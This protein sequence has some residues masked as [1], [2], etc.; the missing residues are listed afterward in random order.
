MK[1]QL[2]ISTL[3]A[4]SLISQSLAAEPVPVWQK[5][6]VYTL[7]TVAGVA[8][9]GPV[10]GI[11]GLAVG[12]FVNEKMDG[13]AQ[14]KTLAP[15]LAKSQQQVDTLQDSLLA[16]DEQLAMMQDLALQRLQ[17]EVF[18]R[19]GDAQLSEQAKQQLTWL[20]DYVSQQEQV[21]IA[22][23]GFAD[24]RGD[25]QFNLDLS[26]QRLA[27]VKNVLIASGVSPAVIE[28]TAYGS[29]AK[30]ELANDKDLDSFALQRKVSVTLTQTEPG[31]YAQ[32]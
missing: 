20:A 27:Q 1:K 31:H 14:A 18:F 26:Q 16:Q 28:T 2:I 3:I 12:D 15:Q 8:I 4:S 21:S 24:P 13:D 9:G 30:S 19:T 29:Q 7:A 5:G 23:A 6:T 17:F 32:Q 22:L 10:G 11:V 25:D